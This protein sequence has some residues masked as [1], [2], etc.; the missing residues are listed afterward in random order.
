MEFHSVSWEQLQRDSFELARQINKANQHI[1][2]IV[3]IA[4]GGM[5]VAQ[6]LSDF[7]GLPVATFTVSSYKDLQ[8]QK[9]SEISFH[10]GGD[11][12]N[13]HILLVDDISD[14]GKTFER[15][16]KYLHELG[17]SSIQT[18]APFIKPGTAHLPDFYRTKT[19]AWVVFPYEIRET[20]DSVAA[21][22]RRENQPNE[23]I[24]SKLKDLNIADHYIKS[25]LT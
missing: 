12:K 8:Q 21:V 4:R 14:T 2:L 20:V 25:F 19:A 1:D 3:A 13:K 9:L 11:V 18:A 6:L 23:A 22:M 5:S 10:V 24:I 15:G 7:L 17:V 16:I